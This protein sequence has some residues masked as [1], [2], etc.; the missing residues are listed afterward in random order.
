MT[1]FLYF[2]CLASPL[3]PDLWLPC[4]WIM[5]MLISKITSLCLDR[6]KKKQSRRT[7]RERLRVSELDIWLHANYFNAPFQIIPKLKVYVKLFASWSVRWGNRRN[8]EIH[9]AKSVSLWPLVAK[10]TR[11]AGCI[12]RRV[13]TPPDS[14]REKSRLVHSWKQSKAGSKAIPCIFTLHGIYAL[15]MALPLQWLMI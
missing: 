5:C 12:W 4:R 15:I 13:L 8:L 3:Q 1:N 9:Q 10:N 2:M 6:F 14:P 7:L 11:R